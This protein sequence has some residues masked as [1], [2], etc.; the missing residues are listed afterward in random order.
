VQ[1]NSIVLGN[2]I[3][4]MKAQRQKSV[5]LLF[6]D[7]PFN[8]GL[9]Y[10]G[11][12]DSLAYDKYVEFS[13][14]WVGAAVDLLTDDGSIYV[15][16][17]DEYAAELNIILKRAGLYQRNWIVWSYTFGQQV[18]TKWARCHTHIL[19]FTKHK[20]NFTFNRSDV[21]VP[22]ARQTKYNDKRASS[23]GKTPDDT[24]TVH[25][26]QGDA[27][28]DPW[29][30]RVWPEDFEI[31]E[32]SRVCGTFKER[33]KDADGSSHPC[34]MPLDV[35]RRIVKA[36]SNPG[37]LVAD[38]FSGTGTTP[39]AAQELGRDFFACEQSPKYYGITAERLG[40]VD[41]NGVAVKP[42]AA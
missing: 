10:D 26:P 42:Q 13:E 34:Q 20:D 25:V 33:I 32:M 21:L 16:I 14:Q 27:K 29:E 38:P 24:W 5:K 18:K 12:H 15:A 19:Y 9:K 8:I 35:L 7:P 22:S 37:D 2:C 17:G 11:Y 31:W 30:L 4:A 41:H 28:I 6:A 39:Y 23:G 40:L 36:S 3:D 1:R